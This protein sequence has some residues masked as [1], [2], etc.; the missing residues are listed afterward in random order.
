[1]DAKKSTVELWPPSF[2]ISIFFLTQCLSKFK[3]KSYCEI[4]TESQEERPKLIKLRK[5]IGRIALAVGLFA[6]GTV[7]VLGLLT[8][9]VSAYDASAGL[10]HVY[11]AIAVPGFVFG[12]L[13]VVSGL[14]AVVLPEGLSQEGT[15]SLQTGPFR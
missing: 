11:D 8:S 14:I 9:V 4:M 10:V 12:I 13:F 2:V 7:I 15:W 5:R 6:I 1:M 3:S